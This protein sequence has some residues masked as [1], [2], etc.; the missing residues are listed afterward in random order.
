[1]F[2]A[3][4]V[5]FLEGYSLFFAAGCSR[6]FKTSSLCVYAIGVLISSLSTL[7]YIPRRIT[8]SASCM[9]RSY[10]R[11]HIQ[12]ASVPPLY[13]FRTE[14]KSRDFAIATRIRVVSR[15]Q[16]DQ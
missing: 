2:L 15:P 12:R 11:L 4:S 9:C 13:Y 7:Y 16:E 3:G 5:T 1:M 14:V 6:V 10:V 8:I